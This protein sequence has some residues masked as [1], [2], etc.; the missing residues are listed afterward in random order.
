MLAAFLS[1]V[2]STSQ[3]GLKLVSVG[4]PSEDDADA[5]LENVFPSMT[6]C[7]PGRSVVQMA[8]LL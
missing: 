4:V 2:L 1:L 7:F 8:A 3:N 5:T 6:M